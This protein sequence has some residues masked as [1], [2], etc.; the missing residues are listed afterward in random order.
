[1]GAA[2]EILEQWEEAIASYQ[3]IV[4]RYPKAPP[5]KEIAALIAY[6][7]ERIQTIKT[8]LWQKEKFE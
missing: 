5:T 1:M 6:A 8:Y 4:Q 2:H 3:I 7:Q